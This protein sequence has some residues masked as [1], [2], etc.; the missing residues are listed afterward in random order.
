MLCHYSDCLVEAGLWTLQSL[1]FQLCLRFG[2]MY[3]DFK[4]LY[5]LMWGSTLF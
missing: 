1:Q 2:T 5:F 3:V 4:M